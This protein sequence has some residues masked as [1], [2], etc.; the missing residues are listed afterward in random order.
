MSAAPKG[1]QKSLAAAL[2]DVIQQYDAQKGGKGRMLDEAID[3]ARPVLAAADAA[4]KPPEQQ[5]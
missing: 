4:K 3:R 2:R 1:D 5:Q